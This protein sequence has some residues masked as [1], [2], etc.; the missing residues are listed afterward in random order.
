MAFNYFN[1]QSYVGIIKDNRINGISSLD[2]SRLNTAVITR[3]LFR[4]K[5]SQTILILGQFQKE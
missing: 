2:S 5:V 3:S 4:N 1:N